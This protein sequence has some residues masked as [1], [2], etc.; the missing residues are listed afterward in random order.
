MRDLTGIEFGL[1]RVLSFSERRGKRLYWNCICRE[2]GATKIVRGDHLTA[3]PHTS[4][5]CAMQ[6]QGGLSTTREYRIWRAM[7]ERCYRTDNDNYAYYGGI[8]RYICARW[9]GSF[10]DF[11][12]DMGQ[13]PDGHSIDRVDT[14]GSYTCGKC[15]ECVSRGDAA[16]CRW[17]NKAEQS[18]NTSNSRYYTHE[19][20]TLI[21]KD[22]AREIGLDYHTL[23][24]RIERGW[25][26]EQAVA[27]PKL[28]SWSRQGPNNGT[29]G[30]SP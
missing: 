9:R 24:A 27:I 26:F 8:G 5:R 20:R 25:S 21:L 10:Q 6:S 3:R 11:L 29:K 13:A 4:C 22:W 7:H 15:A 1:I 14:G 19:G 23:Y 16:N 30:K 17:A 28:E 18:R 12:D 2:C